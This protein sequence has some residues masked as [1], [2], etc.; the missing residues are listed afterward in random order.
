MS[1]HQFHNDIRDRFAVMIEKN[2]RRKR[3][4]QYIFLAIH[5]AVFIIAAFFTLQFSGYINFEGQPTANLGWFGLL[6]AGIIS[7]I[8]HVY[9]VFAANNTTVQDTVFESLMLLMAKDEQSAEK[10]VKAKRKDS[11]ET[12]QLSDDGELI[13]PQRNVNSTR[14]GY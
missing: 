2:K 8:A 5:A 10:S 12:Y 11:D 14:N 6:A 7:L 13:G 3:R 9:A 1:D 4:S